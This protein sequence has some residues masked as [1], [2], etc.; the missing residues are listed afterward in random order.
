MHI[1]EEQELA[2][3]FSLC[4][5][6][7][8][9]LLLWGI[10][11]VTVECRHSRIGAYIISNTYKLLC[12]NISLLCAERAAQ[13]PCNTKKERKKGLG[14]NWYSYIALSS[15]ILAKTI[16]LVRYTVENDGYRHVLFSTFLYYFH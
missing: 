7:L 9:L 10:K 3:S 13:N 8:L 16:L 5:M 12:C 11:R 1:E 6:Y 15:F 14:L 2:R 4:I